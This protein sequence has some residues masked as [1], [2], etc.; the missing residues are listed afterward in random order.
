MTCHDRNQLAAKGESNMSID[1]ENPSTPASEAP[2]TRGPRKAKKAKPAKKAGRAKKPARKPKT[3]G[4]NK[5]PG[6]RNDGDS[7]SFL[8]NTPREAGNSRGDR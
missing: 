4:T 2:A 7:R 6:G 3:E 1:S 5:N 8:S